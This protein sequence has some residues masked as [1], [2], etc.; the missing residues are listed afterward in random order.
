M[1][2]QAVGRTN[3][4]HLP[5]DIPSE[6]SFSGSAS[7]D[8]FRRWIRLPVVYVVQLPRKVPVAGPVA[9]L[10]AVGGQTR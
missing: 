9:V 2:F 5:T 10:Q 1:I 6:E 3:E 7:A 8:P 4:R